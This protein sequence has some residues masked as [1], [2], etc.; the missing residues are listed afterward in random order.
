MPTFQ[1]SVECCQGFEKL[2][3]VHTKQ[4]YDKSDISI[5]S[6][7]SS[8]GNEEKAIAIAEKKYILC[9][10]NNITKPSEMCPC[11]TVHKLIREIKTK[12]KRK[13]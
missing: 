9:K 4:K 1:N 13:N 8:Y 3:N 10:R 2:Y 5:Y 12:I 11:T 7:L 6:K